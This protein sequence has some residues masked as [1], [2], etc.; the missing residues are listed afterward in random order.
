[1]YEI[2][3]KKNYLLI[4]AVIIVIIVSLLLIFNKTATPRGTEYR[5][6]SGYGGRRLPD[7]FH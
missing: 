5:R 3:Q 7:T 4:A 2:N 1:M 6:G